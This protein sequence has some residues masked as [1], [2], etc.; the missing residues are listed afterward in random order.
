[1]AIAAGMRLHIPKA[2]NNFM[3]VNLE[4]YGNE[5]IV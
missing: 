2:L 3:T 1:M 5:V 4:F